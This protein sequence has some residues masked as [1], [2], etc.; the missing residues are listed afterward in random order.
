MLC[1]HHVCSILFARPQ[2]HEAHAATSMGTLIIRITR[3]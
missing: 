2:G 1:E 3:P